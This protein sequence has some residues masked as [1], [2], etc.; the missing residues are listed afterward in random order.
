M[1][2]KF[3]AVRAAKEKI[4]PPFAPRVALLGSLSVPSGPSKSPEDTLASPNPATS[5]KFGNVYQLADYLCVQNPNTP[6][7]AEKQ[8]DCVLAGSVVHI[9]TTCELSC[10][11]GGSF[12]FE[13]KV[14]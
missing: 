1:E 2:M 8:L 14:H 13:Q 12:Q 4:P 10:A 11:L 5:V 6:H 7:L 9:W 3:W